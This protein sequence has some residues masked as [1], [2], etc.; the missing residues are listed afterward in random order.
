M[1]HD[2]ATQ[3]TFF[4]Q[5]NY[6]VLAFFVAVIF[7]L[8]SANNSVLRTFALVCATQSFTATFDDSCLLLLLIR[9]PFLI[10]LAVPFAHA[11]LC[12]TVLAYFAG[13]VA[14][15]TSV[16]APAPLSLCI[17]FFNIQNL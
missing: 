8:L 3:C 14:V 12:A 4:L 13:T 17:V 10:F 5:Y 9:N 1:S 6:L 2:L 7:T 11:K 16:L 15:G